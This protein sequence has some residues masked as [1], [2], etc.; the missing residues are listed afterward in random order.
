MYTGRSWVHAIVVPYNNLAAV[1][2]YY[3]PYFIVFRRAPPGKSIGEKKKKKFANN[4]KQT[5]YYGVSKRSVFSKCSLYWRNSEA[6]AFEIITRVLRARNPFCTHM[7]WRNT[8][9]ILNVFNVHLLHNDERGVFKKFRD[10][11]RRFPWFFPS[12]SVIF[13]HRLSE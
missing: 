2:K 6:T 8:S 13:F 7:L 4:R 3:F 11:H 9:A 12:T 5:E 1:P 10:S